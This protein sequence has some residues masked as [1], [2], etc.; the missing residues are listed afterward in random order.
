[1][2]INTTQLN[3]NAIRELGTYGLVKEK[4]QEL[5]QFLKDFHKP[6]VN[7]FAVL[8]QYIKHTK[9]TENVLAYLKEAMGSLNKAGFDHK[10]NTL[11]NL[12]G[13]L[14]LQN[15]PKGMTLL[16]GFL[17]DLNSNSRTGFANSVPAEKAAAKKIIA[18][19]A[20]SLDA[21]KSQEFLN[22]AVQSGVMTLSE[23]LAV[24]NEISVQSKKSIN[25]SQTQNVVLK[26]ADLKVNPSA[27]STGL[28][29]ERADSLKLAKTTGEQATEAENKDSHIYSQ[30]ISKSG[31]LEENSTQFSVE[32]MAQYAKQFSNYLAA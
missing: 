32:E 16:M 5:K 26:P 4:S 14:F 2:A 8:S 9:V 7:Q 3:S 30:I 15:D 22:Q 17:K 13:N 28:I 1:M 20:K 19:I 31:L 11:T 12:F 25:K 10:I 24:E 23:K 21:A 29:I 27:V 18:Q 6:G